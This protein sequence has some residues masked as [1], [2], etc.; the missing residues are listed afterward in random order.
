MNSTP[1]SPEYQRLLRFTQ[2]GE[3]LMEESPR[4][5]AALMA[6]IEATAR[7]EGL[8]EPYSLSMVAS[9]IVARYMLAN[10]G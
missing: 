5:F 9:G 2:F 1:E 7:G 10:A 4:L 3:L 8:G 6:I